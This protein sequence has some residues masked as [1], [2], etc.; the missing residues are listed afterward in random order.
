MAFQKEKPVRSL[1][2]AFGLGFFYFS[3]KVL[4]CSRIAGALAQVSLIIRP[5]TVAVQWKAAETKADAE[6]LKN[7]GIAGLYLISTFRWKLADPQFATAGLGTGMMESVSA[8]TL[9][10]TIK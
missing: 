2:E 9:S 10:E 1:Y 3:K 4:T 8:V 7:K 5:S 6:T